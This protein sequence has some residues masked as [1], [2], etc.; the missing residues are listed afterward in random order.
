MDE[1]NLPAPIIVGVGRSGT[2]LLRLMLDAHPDV[3]IPTETHFLAD[4]QLDKLSRLSH[5]EFLRIVT[6]GMTWPNLVL[7]KTEFS[8]AVRAIQPFSAG[9]A[10]RCFFRSYAALFGKSRWGDKT[11]RYRSCMSTIQSVLPEAH[12]IHIVR[13]GRD[14]ALSYRGLW[15]GPGDDIATQARFWVAEIEAARRQAPELLHYREVRY[16]DLVA[17]PEATLRSLC[18]ELQLPF[19]PVMLEYHYHAADRLAEFKHV[20]GP[21]GVALPDLRGFVA[22]HS[23]TN[24]PPDVGRVG[25][26]QIEMPDEDQRLYES[27]AG[28]L[29]RELGYETR[30]AG[31]RI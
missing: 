22:I 6:E 13:D 2:T 9:A 5:D 17:Q 28:P 12:F 24:R 26:W 31:S 4:L 19:E 16:E 29:L 7:D 27:I 23:L 8:A 18:L 14:T 20:F 30:F 15:F 10:L 21:E 3:A 11:P 1:A 25:R